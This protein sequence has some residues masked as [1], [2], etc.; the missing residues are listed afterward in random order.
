V[1]GWGI[2]FLEAKRIGDWVKNSGMGSR[3]ASNISNVNK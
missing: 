1:G 3:E 2:T